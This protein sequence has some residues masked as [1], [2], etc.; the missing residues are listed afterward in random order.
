[1]GLQIVGRHRAERELLGIAKGFES[2]TGHARRHP[3]L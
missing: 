3:D 1:M 2:V